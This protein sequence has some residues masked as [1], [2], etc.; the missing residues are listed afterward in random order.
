MKLL[1]LIA[2]ACC[3][4][5]CGPVISFS[6]ADEP[7]AKTAQTDV[8]ATLSKL[9][10]LV[11]GTWVNENPKFVV[12]FR[13]EWAFAKKAIRGLGVIDKGGPHESPGEAIMGPDPVNK[14]VYYL[15]CHGGDTVFKGTVKLD[16]EELIFDF[17]TVVGKPAHWREVLRFPDKDTMQ[18]T[19]FGEKEGKWTPVVKI[20]SRRKQSE[21]EPSRLVTAGVIEAPVQ[22]VWAAMTTKEGQESWNVSH[23]EID[24]K[25][26]G[27]MLTHYDAKGRIG[28]SNT[29]EN[30]ILS[31]E[32]NHMLSIRV[33]NP[34]DKFPFKNAV[35]NVWHVL[36]FEEVGPSRTRLSI[37]GLGYSD[38]DESKKLRA[39]FDDGNAYTLKKLQ[40]KFSGKG[41]KP[42]N[43]G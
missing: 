9:S 25:V 42:S 29:I 4:V 33:G 43:G 1:K 7:A 39:F 3:T 36:H 31:F 22:A 38:D 26:G 23:A 6:S 10:Q 41:G 8:D 30:I 34:P 32:P 16:G 12:E 19:I 24:L 13:Y 27:K 21:L 40:E 2:L 37:V 14:T 11:G 5:V 17:A 35:K 20:T 28:D 15:D 18:F